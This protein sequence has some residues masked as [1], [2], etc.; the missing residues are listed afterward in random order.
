VT[1][2][3]LPPPPPPPTGYAYA[4]P[5]AT[6]QPALEGRA[7]LVARV[8]LVVMAFAVAG[9]GLII[10]LRGISEP[11][12]VDPDLSPLTLIAT[13]IAALGP[14]ALALYFLWREGSIA[15]AGLS[16]PRPGA[17]I[18]WGLLAFLSMVGALFIVGIVIVIVQNATGHTSA[19]SDSSNQI[20][21]TAGAIVGLL[22]ISIVAG[23][24]EE[25]TYR[26]YGITR[27]EQAGWPRAA[28]VAPW[29]VWTAQHLY[30]GP[31]A[32]LVVGSVGV[33]LVLFFRQRRTVYPLIV[34]HALY[35]IAVF[36]IVLSR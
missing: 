30:E 29:L 26:A 20:D 1:A 35:D 11:T 13:A 2:P 14:A 7:R 4:E 36:A 28:L 12:S 21:A 27:M 3:S 10:G 6:T 23:V 22:V 17:V 25:I 15:A 24:S 31:I 16:R 8:E 34:G 19:T 9:P 32:L 5:P 18:G 33:P